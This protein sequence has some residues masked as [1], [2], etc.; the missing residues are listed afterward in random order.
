MRNLTGLYHGPPLWQDLYI[1]F[2]TS[3][4]IDQTLN[5]KP[6]YN[7]YYTLKPE[8]NR[9]KQN[10][11]VEENICDQHN[12]S[13]RKRRYCQKK[14]IEPFVIYKQE[15][16]VRPGFRH[17]SSIVDLHYRRFKEE[18]YR[19]PILGLS[20]G[21]PAS[22]IL[23]SHENYP[24]YKKRLLKRASFYGDPLVNEEIQLENNSPSQLLTID[25]EPE[26]DQITPAIPAESSILTM[27]SYDHIWA[28]GMII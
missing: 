1:Y 11:K 15:F 5:Q 17:F 8:A 25:E 4:S 10:F 24:E 20:E 7:Y 14:N 12:M 19:Q 6:T 23:S 21:L 16:A 3:S 2:T 26:P 13:K 18:Y 22:E 27:Q 28:M 9:A